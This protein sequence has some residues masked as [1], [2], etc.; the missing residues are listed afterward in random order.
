MP[1][2]IRWRNK[3]M[4]DYAIGNIES[5]EDKIVEVGNQFK[6]VHDDWYKGFMAI[7]VACEVLIRTIKQLRDDM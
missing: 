2:Q 6:D 1:K 7:F 3:R 5:A 4:L